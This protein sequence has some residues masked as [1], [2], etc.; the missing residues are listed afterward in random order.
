MKNTQ[1]YELQ[2]NIV[3]ALAHPTRIKLFDILQDEEKTVSDLVKCLE[4]PQPTISRH[5][6]EMR[7]AGLVTPRR[8][9][10]YVYY[11]ISAMKII[12]LNELIKE[13]ASDHLSHRAKQLEMNLPLN[14]II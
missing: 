14:L 10:Q 4:L 7:Y 2:A 1:V 12:K 8:A 9:G 11:R 6:R 5:L 3:Q 13:I